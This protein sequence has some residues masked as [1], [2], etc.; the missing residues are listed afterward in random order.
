MLYKVIAEA[1]SGSEKEDYLFK[2][3]EALKEAFDL[4]TTMTGQYS[5]V[6]SSP[7]YHDVES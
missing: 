2:A 7:V 1:S 4:R 5:M 6:F 3:E